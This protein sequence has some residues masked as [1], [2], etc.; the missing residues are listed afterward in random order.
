MVFF[1]KEIRKSRVLYVFFKKS[2]Q[3][4][5]IT[6]F[7][8][9]LVDLQTMPD[10]NFKYIMHYQDHL[11]KFHLLRSLTSKRASEVARHLLQIFVDFGAPLILQSDNGR[12]FTAEVIQVSF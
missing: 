6:I 12:E 11:S 4:K 10:G 1:Y 7:Q 5:Q 3:I 2:T 8:V 9:D